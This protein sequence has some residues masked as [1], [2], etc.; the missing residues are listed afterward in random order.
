ML[1]LSFICLQPN[2]DTCFWIDVRNA[3]WPVDNYG[4]IQPLAMCA[5]G[6]LRGI[7]MFT[8]MHH[9]VTQ[10]STR[11]CPRPKEDPCCPCSAFHVFLA[12]GQEPQDQDMDVDAPERT[13]AAGVRLCPAEGVPAHKEC[14]QRVRPRTGSSKHM[15]LDTRPGKCTTQGTED[16]SRANGKVGSRS[17][18]HG[19]HASYHGGGSA[20][21][22]YGL[23]WPSWEIGW[24]RSYHTG[25]YE[26]YTP[27]AHHAGDEDTAPPAGASH[28]QVYTPFVCATS[29]TTR[30]VS[31]AATSHID[32]HRQTI[33]QH[34][35]CWHVGLS[36]P[37]P[38]PA[39]HKD[40]VTLLEHIRGAP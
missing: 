31:G 19:G 34:D 36:K 14:G 11:P 32:K 38:R 39:F 25:G 7:C 12:S 28:A 18:Y 20:A 15:T 6:M 10:S 22:G 17:G 35:P 37:F 27:Q 2:R 9:V 33:C 5:S 24:S 30:M 1:G 13:T 8:I 3:V 40:T 29:Y 4:V 16:N 26:Q 23:K 21:C